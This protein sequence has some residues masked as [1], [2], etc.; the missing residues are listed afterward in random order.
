VDALHFL[1]C[2]PDHFF[3]Y[4]VVKAYLALV[5]SHMGRDE[6]AQLQLRFVGYPLPSDWPVMTG[7]KF[8]AKKSIS[9]TMVM[10]RRML[11][12]C[13]HIM[14]NL[15]P[16]DDFKLLIGVDKL[17]RKFFGAGQDWTQ[18][19]AEAKKLA[20][21]LIARPGMDRSVVHFLMECSIKDGPLW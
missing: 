20:E 13:S 21:D 19:Q 11:T 9:L 6:I 17:R 14:Q 18:I 4:G 15:I 10:Y 5:F 1:P 12:I 2:E 8:D 16:D 3:D 7:F